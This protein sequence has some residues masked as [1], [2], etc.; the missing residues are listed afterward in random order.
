MFYSTKAI[1]ARSIHIVRQSYTKLMLCECD[2][3]PSVFN[4]LP[5]DRQPLVDYR[6]LQITMLKCVRCCGG[7]TPVIV[8]IGT[9][10][11]LLA[12]K[13]PEGKAEDV[14]VDVIAINTWGDQ[15]RW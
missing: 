7:K 15:G 9:P 11:L 14:I 6:T 8:K 10:N 12:R 13:H 5:Q 2:A 4:D 3:G 1:A